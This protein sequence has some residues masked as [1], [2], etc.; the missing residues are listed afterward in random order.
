MV[1]NKIKFPRERE[2]FKIKQTNHYKTT[3][4]IF[5][6]I[7]Y[8]Y[9]PFDVCLHVPKQVENNNHIRLIKTLS[10]ITFLITSSGSQ[11]Q[12]QK[13]HHPFSLFRRNHAP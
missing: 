4:H 5:I 1:Y 8:H 11:Q 3:G 2:P 10:L 13:K 9:N 12:Q 7:K 6:Q